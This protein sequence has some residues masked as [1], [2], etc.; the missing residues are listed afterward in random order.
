MQ[1]L[2]LVKAEYEKRI[3][4][5]PKGMTLMECW[6]NLP[7]KKRAKDARKAQEAEKAQEKVL[8]KARG[9]DSDEVGKLDADWFFWWGIGAAV[10]KDLNVIWVKNR[11]QKA[12]QENDREFFIRFGSKLKH[13]PRQIHLDKVALLLAFGWKNGFGFIPPLNYFTD[14]ALLDILQILTGNKSLTFAMLRK[15][16]QRLKLE[17]KERKIKGVKIQ[18]DQFGFDWVDKPEF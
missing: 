9:I 11:V 1:V 14:D 8:L 13:K 16:R 2:A 4:P 5:W 6:Q 10:N 18:G 3:G 12:I 7:D 15:A 17:S